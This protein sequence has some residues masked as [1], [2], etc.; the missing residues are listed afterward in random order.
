MLILAYSTLRIRLNTLKKHFLAFLQNDRISYFDPG[1][2]YNLDIFASDFSG[3]LFVR[4]TKA[5]QNNMNKIKTIVVTA[6]FMAMSASAFSQAQIAIG[7][8]GGLNFANLNTSSLEGTY[9]I[10]IGL[11]FPGAF[12]LIK[13]T[14]IG[15][16]PEII[17]SQQGS[18]K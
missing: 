6:F 8:K 13:L 11:S 18:L 12:T 4:R 5:K 2:Y 3:L 7:L 16:Q 10:C 17:F 9:T 15:I 1:R 14:K